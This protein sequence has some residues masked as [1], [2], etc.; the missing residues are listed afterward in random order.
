MRR[1]QGPRVL[2]IPDTQ[3]KPGVPTEHIAW[4]AR[5]A[6]EH[7]P[8]AIVQ[9][10]DWYDLPSLS[11]YDKGKLESHG[12]Y[13]CDDKRAGD[14]ALD[15]F[16]HTLRR[17]TGRAYHPRLVHL[18]GNHENRAGAVVQD[19]PNLLGTISLDDDA[20]HRHGWTVVPFLKPYKLFGCLYSHFW[21]Q[22]ANGRVTQSKNGAPSARAQVQRVGATCTAG[23]A[24]GLD[25]A[26]VPGPMGLRRG[27][28][29]GSFYMHDEKYAGPM[30]NTMWRG[31]VMKNDIRPD[32]FYEVC[33]VSLDYLRRKFG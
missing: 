8:T 28:I 2:V 33:E 21:P 9:L 6:A 20:F 31:I 1:Q 4:A 19:N 25:T 15:L 27:L 22:S 26:V 18:R 24:Q 7:K 13:F 17:H 10:G 12:K 11:S 30:G 23:H 16:M 32:G 3:V 14:D 5:Y 29:A